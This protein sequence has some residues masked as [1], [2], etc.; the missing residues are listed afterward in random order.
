MNILGGTRGKECATKIM[1]A[2]PLN[3][4]DT[5]LSSSVNKE[6]L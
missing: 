4:N 5:L 2:D 1:I 3:S 6:C